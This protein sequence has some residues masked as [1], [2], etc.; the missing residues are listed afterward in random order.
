MTR[1]AVIKATNPHVVAAYLPANYTVDFDRSTA[2]N[3]VISGEDVAGWTLDDY[4][5]PRLA[6]GLHF[7]QEVFPVGNWVPDR[8][9]HVADNDPEYA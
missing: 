5:L 6:S 3:T 9:A 8:P 4:V 2:D 7:G 1:T